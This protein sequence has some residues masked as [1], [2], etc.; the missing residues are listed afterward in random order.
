[1]L[2]FRAG[3]SRKHPPP[4]L[5]TPGAASLWSPQTRPLPVKKA[6]LCGPHTDTTPACEEGLGRPLCGPHTDTT[7]ACEEGLSVV[8]T[9]KRPLPVKKA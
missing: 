9:Q 6:S 4:S 7:P 2:A 1:M 5:G 8:P 3:Y